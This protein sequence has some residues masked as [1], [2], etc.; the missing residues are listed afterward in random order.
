VFRFCL[1]SPVRDFD[2][3]I[4]MAAEHKIWLGLQNLL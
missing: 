3:Q 1:L 2:A 4:T